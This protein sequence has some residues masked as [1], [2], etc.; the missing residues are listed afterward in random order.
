MD[1]LEICMHIKSNG[2]YSTVPIIVATGKEQ[3]ESL[4]E[5]FEA[6]VQD[7]ITKPLHPRELLARVKSK[8]GSSSKKL[9][10]CYENLCLNLKTRVFYID[11]E[12]SISQLTPI[13]FEILK[14]F[15]KRPEH[16][17]SRAQLLESQQ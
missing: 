3:I 9:Q 7:Y 16:V 2:K 17:F 12:I 10:I 15:L 8:I 5:C 13:E 14:A 6:G 4:E 1:G 11:K